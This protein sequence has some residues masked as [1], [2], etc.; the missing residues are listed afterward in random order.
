M[1]RVVLV[2][3]STWCIH[4]FRYNL[5]K[6]LLEE[7][8]ELHVVAPLDP[9]YDNPTFIS[10]FRKL[11][12]AFHPIPLQPRGLN[13]LKE[14]VSVISL[15][16]LLRAL[17]PD[18]VLTYTVKCNLYTGF[19]RQ[20][21]NF[22]QIANVP[23]LGE[24]FERR[25]LL[26]SLVCALYRLSFRGISKA[27]FQNA[28]DLRYCLERR[29]VPSDKCAVIPGSGVDLSR[30]STAFPPRQKAKRT[31]LMFGR[32]LPQKGY[33]E[34]L[35]AARE[36]KSLLGDQVECMIMGI[37]DR[38]RPE[39]TA[40]LAKIKEAQAEGIVT[41][42]PSVVDVT[43]VLAAVDAVVLPSRYNEGVPRSLLEALASG[44]VIIT[45]D[46][47]GCRETVREGKNGFL[48]DV[49][50]VGDLV[51]AFLKVAALDEVAL[52][53][54]GKQSRAL[55][56]ERFDEQLVLDEYMRA[57]VG[58]VPTD[59]QKHAA[60]LAERRQDS[61][62]RTR[63]LS[64]ERVPSEPNVLPIHLNQQTPANQTAPAASGLQLD[65]G[66]P[67]EIAE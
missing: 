60:N 40:L 27:F 4:N 51:Q 18:V 45:T 26:S 2:A 14:L 1:K 32:L 42:L 37:E 48:V 25:G 59:R 53:A 44:K 15:F 66:M 43:P 6:Q 29:L 23:G 46:W 38:N 57:V 62:A 28:E 30:F 17:S 63:M 8:C 16:K 49:N 52:R 41:L 33:R 56:E 3:N 9:T 47:R 61:L 58:H 67:L 39:S 64:P 21:L 24:V 11:G 54:M 20:L 12:I 22:S 36:I 55:V 10:A 34:Y 5:M 7:G 50:N 35:E 13:P 19:C 65:R 31:F